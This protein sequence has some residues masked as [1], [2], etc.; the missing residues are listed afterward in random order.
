MSPQVSSYTPN[1]KPAKQRLADELKEALEQKNE[2][3]SAR[4][5]EKH[6]RDAETDKSTQNK[7]E[8]A[9]RF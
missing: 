5:R 4:N 3:R 9:M 6:G 2:N 7:V 1:G 8:R